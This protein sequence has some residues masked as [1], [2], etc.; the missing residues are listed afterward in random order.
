MNTLATEMSDLIHN[1]H[2]KTYTPQQASHLYLTSGDLTDWV[3]GTLRIPAFTIE[4]RPPQWHIIPGFE[5]PEDEIL[6]TCEENWP[7]AFYLI[8]WVVLSQGGFMDFEDGVDEMPIRSTIPGMTF[9]T[10]MG[11]DWVYG[12]IRTGKYNVYPYGH[13]GYEC[14]GNFFAW[15]GPYQGLGRID[16]TGATARTVSM[17]TSTH[18][19]TYLEAYDSD[20]NLVASDYAGPNTFTRTM[21]QIT[22]TSPSIAY[23]IVHDT[24]N[25]WLIDDLRVR[26]LLRET[27]AFQ[28]PDS[29]SMFQTLDTIDKGATSTYEFTNNQQ[30]TLKILLNWQGSTLGIQIFRPDGTVF[31]ETQ[32]DSPPI[33]IVIP[34][35]EAGTWRAAI[36]AIDVPFDDYPFAIDVAS[37]PPPPDIEPPK[38]TVKTPFEG[39]A[40]QDGVTLK[41][42]VSDP[43]GVGWITFSVREP[44]GEQGT[45]ID[46]MFESMPATYMG[47]D[48]WE[49]LFDTTQLPDGYYLLLVNASDKLGNEGYVTVE[50]SIRNWACLELLPASESNKAG[51]TMPVKFSLRVVEVVDPAQPFVWNEELTIVIYEKD[52][53]ENILQTSTYGTTARD[54]RIDPEDELYITNF[55]TLKTPTTYVVEIY[56][57]GML[58]GSFEFS[59]VK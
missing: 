52:N 36:T 40:L 7:A 8:R 49:L 20:G 51:R 10:T 57:K 28:P 56:R 2:G 6:D 14:H 33:R 58:I 30:Q 17:L 42:L 44:D 9:T 27:N 50:F 16:F 25:Y 22:V 29:T 41:A 23:V 53:P 1:V 55:K 43:S 26:D 32:S 13:A 59:T 38:I 31:F 39:Q 48:Q 5:L 34:S 46:P 54:Y 15:L 45:I 24:G 18:Y 4:L 47:D 11:Y 37:V 19:G 3:Y 12:D 35:A 21:T